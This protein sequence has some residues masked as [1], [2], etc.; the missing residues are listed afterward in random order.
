MNEPSSQDLGAAPP[1]PGDALAAALAAL[2]PRRPRRPLR[3]LAVVL[4]SMAMVVAAPLLMMGVR[5]DLGA[6]PRS[7]ALGVG[8][9]WLVL[10]VALA[11]LVLLPRRGQALMR[12]WLAGA[13]GAG[14]AALAVALGALVH[15]PTTG[16]ARP[17]L[18]GHACLDVGLALALVPI[19]CALL[20]LRRAVPTGNAWLGAGLGAAG[21]AAAGLALHLHCPYGDALHLAIMHGGVV[22]LASLLGALLAAR[23]T[24]P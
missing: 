8:A 4:G 20:L 16:A 6:L 24:R 19:G 5:R 9:I 3:D 18:A 21:G 23:F 17:V 7:Y 13:I 15:P 12:P 14:S 10:A 2:Q 1:P 11:A 22:V